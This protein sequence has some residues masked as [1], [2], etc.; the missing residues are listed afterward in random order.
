M[1]FIAPIGRAAAGTPP[2]HDL[3]YYKALYYP[4]A[5]GATSAPFRNAPKP[6]TEQ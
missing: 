3:A 4:Y 2:P 1:H 5:P 6:P